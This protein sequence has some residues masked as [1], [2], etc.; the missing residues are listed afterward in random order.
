MV[1]N[2]AITTWP[3]ARVQRQRPQSGPV[4]SPVYPGGSKMTINGNTMMQQLFTAMVICFLLGR[5][6]FAQENPR[7]NETTK[8]VQRCLP[9]VVSLPTVTPGEKP[10]T[11][12]VHFGSGTVITPSGYVLTN[13]HVVR[14][15]KQGQALLPGNRVLRYATICTIPHSDLA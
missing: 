8:L 3:V 2:A 10:G 5:A 15:F 12:N 14:S 13:A 4:L 7:V 11:Q 1:G 9:A 6:V